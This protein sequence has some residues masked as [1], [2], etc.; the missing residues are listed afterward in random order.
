M[1]VRIHLRSRG[2]RRHTRKRERIASLSMSLFSPRG[3]SCE[4]ATSLSCDAAY[5]SVAWKI[6]KRPILLAHVCMAHSSDRLPPLDTLRAFEAAARLGSFSAAA[7]ELSLTHGAIS[8]QVARLEGWLGQRLFE[9]HGRG[10]SVTQDGRRLQI[11]TVEAFA[12]LSDGGDRWLPARGPA[13][14]RLTALPSVSSL[15]LIPRMTRLEQ[16][17]PPLQIDL[18]IEGRSADLTEEGI[19]LALRWGNGNMPGRVSMCLLDDRAFPIASP[20]L[21]ARIG[22]GAPERLLEFP[23]LNDSDTSGWRRWFETC[24]MDY[25]PRRSDRR[26]ED[27]SIVLTAVAAGLGI[28][29]A[30]PSLT[31]LSLRSGRV[32]QV[33]PRTAPAAGSYWLDRPPGAVRPAAAT[34]AS[35]IASEAGIESG[36]CENFLMAAA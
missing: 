7:S 12:L 36:V 16:G 8:R 23:L 27:Y 3:R 17:K 22:D 34:L 18:M 1:D 10:V 14:V 26:F 28:G 32:V 19:D 13:V 21:A 4:P 5:V 20:E 35:R 33:D 31:D 24:G 6:D 30:R 2:K 29:L 25:R 9:R 11:R 15:W